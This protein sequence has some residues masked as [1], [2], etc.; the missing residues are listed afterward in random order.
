MATVNIILMVLAAANG[1]GKF[2]DILYTKWARKK[3]AV[4][5][6]VVTSSI[7]EQFK[8]IPLAKQCIPIENMG[9]LT[10]LNLILFM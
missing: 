1:L 9:L 7:V 3:S 10:T 4:V 5:L 2:S 6:R 8:E